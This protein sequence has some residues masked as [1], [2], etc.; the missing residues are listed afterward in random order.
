VPWGHDALTLLYVLGFLLS[1]ALLAVSVPL[2]VTG[3][4]RVGVTWTLL[5]VAAATAVVLPVL[6]FSPLGQSAG[7]WWMD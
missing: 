1:P 7:V 6:M 4:R 2:L 3:R 5:L